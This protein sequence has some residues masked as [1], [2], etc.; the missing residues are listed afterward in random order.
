MLEN[1]LHYIT[2]S[3]FLIVRNVLDVIYHND[4]V[5]LGALVF[6]FIVDDSDGDPLTVTINHDKKFLLTEVSS[7]NYKVTLKEKLDRETTSRYNLQVTISDG[8]S[9]TVSQ[10]FDPSYLHFELLFIMAAKI[11]SRF[12]Y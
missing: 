3:L 2:N 10:F 9:T 4:C 11:Y 8:T 7:N 12:C 6:N 1:T 5:H